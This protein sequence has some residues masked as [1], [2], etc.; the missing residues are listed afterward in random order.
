MDFAIYLKEILRLKEKWERNMYKINVK[1]RRD[2]L[3][4]KEY[5]KIRDSSYNKI[6]NKYCAKNIAKSYLGVS[7][8]PKYCTK[9]MV[10]KV[11]E[12]NDKY[13]ICKVKTKVNSMTC[14]FRL[15]FIKKKWLIDKITSFDYQ[16]K[17]YRESF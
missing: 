11:L 4:D 5:K 8:P 3:S 14:F 12:K 9:G 7:K 1:H 2:E 13:V 17:E 16:D 6:Y 15:K 10:I